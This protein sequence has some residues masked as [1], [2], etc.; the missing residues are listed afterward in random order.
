MPQLSIRQSGGAN[1]VSIPKSVVESLGLRVGSTL[2]L[3]VENDRI[4]LSPSDE[5]M[6]L[7]WLLE[8]SPVENLKQTE[9]DQHWLNAAPKGNE[10]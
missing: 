7:E 10:I 3:S 9:E 4:I 5:E 1:I 8:G 2:D 6:T